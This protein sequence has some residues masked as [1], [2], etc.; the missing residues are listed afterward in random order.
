MKI[1]ESDFEY[2]VLF[3]NEQNDIEHSIGYEYLPNVA[4][5][6]ENFD[7]LKND[8]EFK[9]DNVDSLYIDIISKEQYLEII[10]DLDLDF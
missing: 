10:G 9:L 3:I 7:E 1:S 2:F 8:E 5:L 4:S 6:L